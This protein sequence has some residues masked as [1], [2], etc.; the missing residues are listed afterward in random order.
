KGGE[1]EGP[2]GALPGRW[3]TPAGPKGGGCPRTK[4]PAAGTVRRGYGVTIGKLGS[5]VSRTANRRSSTVTSPR[6]STVS[7]PLPAS[8]P[9]SWGLVRVS[10]APAVVG[11][12]GSGQWLSAPFGSAVR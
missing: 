2:A 10:V 7:A 4:Q 3:R 5:G 9:R 11:S 6:V 1:G 12:A 8:R